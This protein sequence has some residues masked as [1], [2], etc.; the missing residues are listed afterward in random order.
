MLFETEI[1][2]NSNFNHNPFMQLVYGCNQ[3]LVQRAPIIIIKKPSGAK[4]SA[5][6]DNEISCCGLLECNVN[7]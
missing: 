6:K 2:I 7:P 5:T 1:P 4:G 3:T